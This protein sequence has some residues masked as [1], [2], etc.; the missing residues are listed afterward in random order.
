MKDVLS[1]QWKT[2]IR[3]KTAG[4]FALSICGPS[5]VGK[6]TTIKALLKNYPVFIE[7]TEGNRHLSA[8]LKNKKDFNAAA[9][10]RWFL[11][12]IGKHI[13]K[14]NP[15]LPLILDQDPAAIVLAYA[16]M[17]FED[18]KI[19]KSQYESLFNRLLKIEKTLHGWKC[20]RTVLFLDAPAEV[21]YHRALKRSGKTLTPPLEWFERVRSHFVQLFTC[22]PNAFTISTARNSPEQVVAK[23]KALIERKIKDGQA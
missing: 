15:Q 18:G 14:A 1:Q 22:F 12:Q 3:K 8:L 5:G 11:S 16:K 7:T 21:L 2:I 19:K 10:Q 13:A 4:D 20:P 9:N 23:A 6:T 17:F